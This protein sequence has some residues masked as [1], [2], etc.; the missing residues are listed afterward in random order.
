MA[1]LPDGMSEAD[2]RTILSDGEPTREERGAAARLEGARLASRPDG[3]CRLLAPIRETL[4]ADFPPE[5][6]D[7]TRLL[8]LFFARAKLREKAGWREWGEVSEGLIAEAGNDAMIGVPE[9]YSIGFTYGRL[10]RRAATPEE[11][12]DHREAARKTWESIGRQDLI[13]IYLG[14]GA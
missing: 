12:A 14:E 9:P 10:A 13:D 11:A 6:G 4:L 5:P 1:L 3:R 8:D 2:G 7:R